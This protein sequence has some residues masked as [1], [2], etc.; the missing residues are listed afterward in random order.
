MLYMLNVYAREMVH[1]FPNGPQRYM[2]TYSTY[3]LRIPIL[4]CQCASDWGPSSEEIL[5]VS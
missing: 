2:K 3:S 4:T 5:P 1:F